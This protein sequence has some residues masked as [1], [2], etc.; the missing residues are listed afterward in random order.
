M[1]AWL[2][3][4][5]KLWKVLCVGKVM[6]NYLYMVVTSDEYE[7]P[8]MVC[9]SARELAEKTGTTKNNV[10]SCIYKQEHGKIKNSRYRRVRN[11][12]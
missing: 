4:D 3:R 7:L 11:E 5:E 12:D 9:D 6:S 8:L 10:I 1:V 2:S